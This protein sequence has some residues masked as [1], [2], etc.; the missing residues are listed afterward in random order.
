MRV[1][2]AKRER[3]LAEGIPPYPV[4]LPRT[5]TLKEIREK[6]AELPTDTASGDIVEITGRVIFVRNGGKLCFATLPDGDGT[7]LQAMLSLDKVVERTL[8]HWN[9]LISLGDLVGIT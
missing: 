9:Y 4:N 5:A 3:F 1:R 6:Y 8:N 2:R 7:E